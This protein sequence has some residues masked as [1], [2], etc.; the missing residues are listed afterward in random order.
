MYERTT[1]VV[2]ITT[3]DPAVVND[4]VDNNGTV[5]ETFKTSVNVK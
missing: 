4:E 5:L 1:V 2:V 3:T